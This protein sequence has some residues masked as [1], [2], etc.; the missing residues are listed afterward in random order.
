MPAALQHD[1]TLQ[2]I[3]ATMPAA[4]FACQRPACPSL[5]SHREPASQVCTPGWHRLQAAFFLFV[6]H[7]FL[8]FSAHCCAGATP[9][10]ASTWRAA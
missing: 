9:A 2:S 4:F 1:V 6:M 5:V 3:P 10:T 7:Y 8:I